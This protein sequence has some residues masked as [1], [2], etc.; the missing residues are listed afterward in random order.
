MYRSLFIALLA[1]CTL[2]ARADVAVYSQ[3]PHPAGGQYKSSWYATDGLDSDEHVWDAFIVPIN[4]AITRVQWR[5]GYAYGSTGGRSPVYD[6]TVSIHASTAGGT[7]PDVVSQ[8]LVRY[9]TN[10]NAGEAYAATVNGIEMY[11]YTFTFPSAFQ[12]AAGTKYWVQ[13]EAY[14]GLTPQYYWPPDWSIAR[15]IGGEN[16]H[17]RR[18]G[19][20]GGM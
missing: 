8:P 14:Q 19:G 10:G 4:S 12:A 16:S 15:G 11:D 6:F 5:G 3:T 20:T 13:I 9:H 18:V 2:A 7:Q 17:F 1:F